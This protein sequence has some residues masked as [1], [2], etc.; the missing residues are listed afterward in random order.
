MP[1]IQVSRFQMDRCHQRREDHG[2]VD[3]MSVDYARSQRLSYMQPEEEE[4]NEVEE[5]RPEYRMLRA[6]H[7]GRDDGGDRIGGVVKAVE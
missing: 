7:P 2:R 6:Q 1:N 4:C 5:R 3:D